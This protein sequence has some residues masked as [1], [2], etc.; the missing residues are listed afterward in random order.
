MEQMGKTA[1]ILTKLAELDEED[2]ELLL[3]ALDHG[4]HDEW[5]CTLPHGLEMFGVEEIRLAV[6]SAAIFVRSLDNADNN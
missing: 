2:F 5:D 4:M 3:E 1:E 6:K